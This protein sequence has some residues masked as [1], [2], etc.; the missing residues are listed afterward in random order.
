[1]AGVPIATNLVNISGKSATF[2]FV[3][4]VDPGING[5]TNEPNLITLEVDAGSG[6][7]TPA[8]GT[9]PNAVC[10]GVTKEGWKSNYGFQETKDFC[11][12]FSAA[13]D[14]SIDQEELTIEASAMEVARSIAALE[15]LY[16]IAVYDNA[17]ASFHIG[18]G[19]ATSGKQT[20]LFMLRRQLVSGVYKYEYWFNS[21]TKQLSAPVPENFTA[22]ERLV[23]PVKFSVLA[24][25]N[26]AT[27]GKFFDHKVGI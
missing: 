4:V 21:N 23:L 13:I 17:P 10:V 9:N 18:I 24:M 22:K 20:T 11:D 6:W 26:R 3:G 19:G 16:D 7:K 8:Q 15:A 2:V 27:N 12:E 1:M 14:S 25:A 5:T